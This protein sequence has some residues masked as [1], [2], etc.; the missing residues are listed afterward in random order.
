M[1]SAYIAHFKLLIVNAYRV[2]GNY[3]YGNAKCGTVMSVYDN[4]T[5]RDVI[6][7]YEYGDG[8]AVHGVSFSND[9]RY[10]Y[11]ADDGGNAIWVHSIN[12]SDGTLT[13]QSRLDMSDKG[14]DPRHVVAHPDGQYVYT[15]LEGTSQ[16][17][18]FQTND[19][20][21]LYPLQVSYPLISTGDKAAD[22]WADEVALSAN[23]KYLWASNRAHDAGRKG[24]ISAIEVQDS[25]YLG[26]QFFLVETTNSG[27]FANA[28]TPSPFDDAIVAITD[29]STGFIEVWKMDDDKAGAKAVAHLDINDRGGC[30]ANAVWYS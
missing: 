28:V 30:C 17:A 14:S 20:H 6:Q 1:T 19:P 9:F 7:G 2:Y 5:L 18:Q 26:K 3:F 11:S 10:L 8:S 22:Y 4:G 15:V 12:P 21:K 16:V 24:Y 13:F 25:G 29:N 27:G 23:S